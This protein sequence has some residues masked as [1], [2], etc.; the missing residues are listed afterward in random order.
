MAMLA[1]SAVAAAGGNLACTAGG[2]SG[3]FLS[4]TN[5]RK[6]RLASS[7]INVPA[8]SVCLLVACRSANTNQPL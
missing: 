7:A 5:S 8:W 2:A 4:P 1:G 3:F 6:V